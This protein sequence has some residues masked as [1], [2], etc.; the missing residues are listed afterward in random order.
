MDLVDVRIALREKY[1]YGSD[2]D[3]FAVCIIVIITVT[4]RYHS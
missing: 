2:V 3:V 1:D 4:F